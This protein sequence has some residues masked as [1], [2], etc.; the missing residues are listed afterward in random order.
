MESAPE[1]LSS[2]LA[3]KALEPLDFY[4]LKSTNKEKEKGEEEKKNGRR[5][6][7]EPKAIGFDLERKSYQTVW[8]YIEKPD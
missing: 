6:R 5:K 7:F 1:S 4:A 3:A 8:R 2:H